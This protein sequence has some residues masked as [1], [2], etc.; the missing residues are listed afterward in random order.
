MNTAGWAGRPIHSRSKGEENERV[1]EAMNMHE[2]LRELKD[3]E[4]DI[5][6]PEVAKKIAQPFGAEPP[7]K[8]FEVGRDRVAQFKG[9]RGWGVCAAELA[10]AIADHLQ[11]EYEDKLG[12]GSRLRAACEALE[13]W[14][15]KE[16]RHAVG[17]SSRMKVQL[18]S[19]HEVELEDQEGLERLFE[20]IAQHSSAVMKETPLAVERGLREAA[21]DFCCRELHYVAGQLKHAR[22]SITLELLLEEFGVFLES[23]WRKE[24]PT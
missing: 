19:G 21:F 14:L 23:H 10:E 24:E 11:L 17:R 12:I 6:Y 15:N 22:T 2:A 8:F 5:L 4:H 16:F 3:S 20:A 13:V 1:G 18:S 7:V 9:G